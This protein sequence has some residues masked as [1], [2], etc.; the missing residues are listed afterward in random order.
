[1]IEKAADAFINAFLEDL[2]VEPFLIPL[3]THL[4]SLYKLA[5][6]SNFAYAPGLHRILNYFDLNHFFDTIII[7]GEFGYRKPNPRIF[8]EALKK[9]D[10]KPSKSVFIGD[11]LKADIYGAKSVGM[12]T[13]L[14]E[15]CGLRKNPYA[16]AGELDPY[17]VKPDISLPDLSQL[18]T[19][20][21]LL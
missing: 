21:S 16:T 7:S 3:L 4:K 15:N 20:L 9:L 10:I 11:S 14:V 2:R 18:S 17:P 12:K 1:V 8:E 6:I 19:S 13:I 5:M